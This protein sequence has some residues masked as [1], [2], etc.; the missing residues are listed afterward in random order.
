VE[1]D[2]VSEVEIVP[3]LGQASI[4]STKRWSVRQSTAWATRQ[5]PSAGGH[6]DI[7][8]LAIRVGGNRVPRFETWHDDREFV[9]AEARAKVTSRSCAVSIL[10][11]AKRARLP[12]A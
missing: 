2:E 5:S 1:D 3:V 10:L 11:T 12:A 4:G 9:A 6:P 8:C 7:V